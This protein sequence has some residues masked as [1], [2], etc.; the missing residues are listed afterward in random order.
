[1]A[2]SRPP[3]Q[4][5]ANRGGEPGFAQAADPAQVTRAPAGTTATAA[6][7]EADRNGAP[8]ALKTAGQAHSS[9]SRIWF[10]CAVALVVS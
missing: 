1:M 8:D 4:L 3:G 2:G 10:T 9:R 6:R 5:T 7:H